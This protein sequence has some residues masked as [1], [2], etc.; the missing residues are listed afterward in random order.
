MD[1]RWSRSNG[2]SSRVRE[3]DLTCLHRDT[4]L[5]MLIYSSYSRLGEQEYK[6]RLYLSGQKLKLAWHACVQLSQQIQM[7]PSHRYL[8]AT[9]A[10]VRLHFCGRDN[11]PVKSHKR[12]KKKKRKEKLLLSRLLLCQCQF[13]NSEF[14]NTDYCINNSLLHMMQTLSLTFPFIRR[15]KHVP[16]F[17]CL[18][19]T[20]L[21]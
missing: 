15:T 17:F 9:S 7:K 2:G 19:Q 11:S 8:F 3:D 21:F 20:T 1:E 16:G 12:G 13:G 14:L 18:H 4:P 6:Y 10:S 5:F